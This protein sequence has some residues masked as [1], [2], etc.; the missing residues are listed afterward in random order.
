MISLITGLPGAGKTLFALS[1]VKEQAEKDGRPVYYSG[2]PD[3]TLPWIEQDADKWHEIPDGSI[4]V[5]DECQR[6]FRPRGQGAQVPEYVSKLETHRHQGID[7]YLVTQHPMLIDANVRRLTERHYHVARRF[8]MQG[9]TV[10]Q[11]ESCK[12]QP[13]QK[14]E[15]AQ[16]MQWRYPKQAFGYYKSAQVHTVKRRIPAAFWVLLAV[17]V[18]IGGLGYVLYTRHWE[19]GALVVSKGQKAAVPMTPV[20]SEAGGGFGGGSGVGNRPKPLTTAEYLAA[21]KERIPGLPHTAPRYDEVTKPTVA[22]VPAGA[23]EMRGHCVAFTDQG[24]RIV[25]AQELCRTILAH[26]F[27]REFQDKGGERAAPG[28]ASD[29]AQHR[30][31]PDRLAAVSADSG[32]GR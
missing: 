27:Y 6:V 13:L 20:Q 12:D 29:R 1:W 17:P 10:L 16:R 2:I 8:G 21:Y 7:I 9:A 11:F 15:G 22:P 18:L 19:D 25:M 32:L 26:G 3:L 30:G 23:V 24:T 5:I 31:S 4:M 14:M 28:R